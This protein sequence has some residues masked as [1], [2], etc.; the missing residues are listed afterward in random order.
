MLDHLGQ[1]SIPATAE[2]GPVLVSAVGSFSL[3]YNATAR[4]SKYIDNID[5]VIQLL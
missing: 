2:R 1:I 5:K 4:H 3:A